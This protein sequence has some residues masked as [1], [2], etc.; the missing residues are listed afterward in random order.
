MN[1]FFI[2][3]CAGI[4]FNP[5]TDGSIPL[6]RT[7]EHGDRLYVPVELPDGQT[8]YFILDTGASI[9]AMSIDVAQ[10]LEL[11]PRPERGLLVGVS[12]YTPWASVEVPSIQIGKTKLKEVTFAVGV[13]GL[14]RSAGAVPVSGILGNNVLSQ[15]IVDIDYVSN[16]LNL[17]QINQFEMPLGSVSG[18]FDGGAFASEIA[19][20]YTK[21]PE[22]LTSNLTIKIDTGSRGLL[23]NANHVPQL[24][25]QSIETLNN[26]SGIGQL[27]HQQSEDFIRNTT[28]TTVDSITI[29]KDPIEGPFEATILQMGPRNKAS[30]SLLGHDVFEGKRLIID[31]GKQSMYLGLSDQNPDYHDLHAHRLSALNWGQRTP[32]KVEEMINIYYATD[33]IPKGIDLLKSTL[34]KEDNVSLKVTLSRLYRLIGDT[35]NALLT[36]GELTN[37]QLLEQRIWLEQA[38]LLQLSDQL[39]D[40][41]PLH[42]VNVSN[43]DSFET[44]LAL[45]DV[46]YMKGKYKESNQYLLEALQRTQNPNA[47]LFRRARLRYA[48]GD[49][50]GAITQLRQLLVLNPY[51]GQELWFY[52][53]IAKQ[54][55]FHELALQDLDKA[56]SKLY[57]DDGAL[58]FFS[59]AYH[60]LG[61]EEKS[62][63]Y[64]SAGLKRD[65]QD[66]ESHIKLNCTVWYKAMR[67]N[68]SSSELDTMKKLIEEYPARSDFL[69]TYA[70]ALGISGQKEEALKYSKEAALRDPTD[71]YMLWQLEAINQFLIDQ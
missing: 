12:G 21:G 17:H 63:K 64:Q 38:N 19:L 37:A 10:A 24:S 51:G 8:H 16:S 53:L 61:D 1:L 14:P 66:Q 3:G 60:L 5:L 57:I 31:Y 22:K 69:D 35:Q 44:S 40:L 32:E 34:K 55:E 58:D 65:C 26:I 33:Q 28:K 25:E 46:Y 47:F 4:N 62:Q 23:L 29:N 49:F 39:E 56:R 2:L 13:E 67:G 54:S 7:A 45:S 36:M 50:A 42:A 70:V 59:A 71:I 52:A 30:V 15:F 41:E 43:S 18:S 20:H 48:L 9:S 11:T 68:I 27:A 6:Y